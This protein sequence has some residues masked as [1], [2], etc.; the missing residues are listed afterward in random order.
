VSYHI[1]AAFV[2]FA[3]VVVGCSADP[4][5]ALP[6]VHPTKGVVKQAGKPVTGG[7]V[8]FQAEN[9]T[10]A[11]HLISGEVGPDGTFVLT[12]SH[13]LDRNA[14]RKKGVPAGRYRVTYSAVQGDQTA[15]RPTPPVQLPQLFTVE[16][17][18]N[19]LTIDVPAK[20]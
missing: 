4:A 16:A 20:K 6:E 10:G 13:A 18:D 9:A 12:T 14:D 15:G 3:F 19:N 11:D 1:R 5:T 8:Q 7:F 2:S 17:G